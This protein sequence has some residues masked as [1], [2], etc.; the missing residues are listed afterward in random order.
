MLA[1]TRARIHEVQ[2]ATAGESASFRK[3]AQPAVRLYIEHGGDLQAKLAA[4]RTQYCWATVIEANKG[5][6]PPRC[7]VCNKTTRSGAIR[8]IIDHMK[9]WHPEEFHKGPATQQQ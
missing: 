9:N 6:G 7:P 1:P 8:G 4:A 5:G 2:A 3:L